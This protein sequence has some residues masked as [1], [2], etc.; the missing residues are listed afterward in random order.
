MISDW[1][2][3]AFEFAFGLEKP[4]IFINLPKKINNSEFHLYESIPLEINL[5]KE[6]G[7]IVEMN[8]TNSIIDIINK[9]YNQ[10]LKYKDKIKKIRNKTIYNISNSANKGAEYI[11]NLI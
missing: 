6:I 7:E 1:S 3:S 9:V 5:R 11:N 4:V 8:D 2:G 10:K